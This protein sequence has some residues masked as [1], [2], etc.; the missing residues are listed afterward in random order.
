M[1]RQRRVV[2]ESG[3]PWPDMNNAAVESDIAVAPHIEPSRPSASGYRAW[4]VATIPF[5][6]HGIELGRHRKECSFEAIIKK[7]NLVRDP[8]LVL[9]SKIVN[10]ADADNTL[11]VSAGGLG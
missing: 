2:E 7:Y 1:T 10:G 11:W 6:V 3:L 4:P 8:A 9:L 5:D